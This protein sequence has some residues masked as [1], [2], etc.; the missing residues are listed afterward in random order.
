M[1]NF[2]ENYPFWS[3]VIFS[4]AVLICLGIQWYCFDRNKR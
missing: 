3:A 2:I 4:V 1:R